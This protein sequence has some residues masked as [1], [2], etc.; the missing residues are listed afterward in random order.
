M[1]GLPRDLRVLRDRLRT[2]VNA[3]DTFERLE[4][5]NSWGAPA[6]DQTRQGALKRIEQCVIDAADAIGCH[7]SEKRLL[8]DVIWKLQD[9]NKR[10]TEANARLALGEPF[11]NA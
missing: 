11:S 3:L 8:S 10:L 1:N 4:L 2:A 6:S 5:A 7:P 9:E